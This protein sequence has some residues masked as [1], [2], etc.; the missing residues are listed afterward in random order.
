MLKIK[1]Q[2]ANNNIIILIAASAFAT[3]RY[4]C[5]AS[6]EITKTYLQAKSS[7]FSGLNKIL[8]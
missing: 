8:G 4:H 6:I 7:W 1:K 2:K 5:V 3:I